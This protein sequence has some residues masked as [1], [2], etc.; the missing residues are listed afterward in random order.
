MWRAA[1]RTEPL[2]WLRSGEGRVTRGSR[3]SEPER[4]ARDVVLER[5]R[6]PLISEEKD[7]GV[8][9]D[10]IAGARRRKREGFRDDLRDVGGIAHDRLRSLNAVA[11]AQVR[12]LV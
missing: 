8:E 2:R 7:L 3:C 9:T 4:N 5:R 12:R 6:H 10:E 1:T 11:R